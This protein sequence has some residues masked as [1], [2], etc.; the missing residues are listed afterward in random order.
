[1]RNREPLFL[2]SY[3]MAVSEEILRRSHFAD[4]TGVSYLFY[5]ILAVSCLM[6]LLKIALDLYDGR[7]R[8]SY[9]VFLIAGT[10][11]MAFLVL[12]GQSDAFM[13]LWLFIA[14]SHDVDFKKIIKTAAISMLLS[15]LLVFISGAVGIIENTTVT[16]M[17]EG[18]EHDRSGLG[19][20]AAYHPAYFFFFGMLSWFYY[21]GKKLSLFEIAVFAAASAYIFKQSDTRG[22][23]LLSVLLIVIAGIYRLF[24]AFAKHRRFY[25]VLGAAVP[26]MAAAFII[27]QG[28]EMYPQ[29]YTFTRI[30][31]KKLST[32]LWLNYNGVHTYGITLLGQNINWSIGDI[33]NVAY[34]WVDSVYL[35]SLLSYGVPFLLAFLYT[36]GR[37]SVS[38]GKKKDTFM[39][40][41]LLLIAVLGMLDN[42]C[43]RVE[44][45]P[46]YLGLS[47]C[48]TCAKGVNKTF[49]TS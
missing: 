43:F 37:L 3:A 24:P 6:S 28:I 41:A 21:R 16:R 32:R 18:E 13:V 25:T 40:I 7:I 17:R 49:T 34:N 19:F 42:Y 4:I 11:Y 20:T 1:M 27:Y 10:A 36:S 44:C 46:F 45:N 48:S 39:I 22:P 5:G 31:N 47:Y 15:V 2:T 8:R 26:V 33:E 9:L 14:A 12:R 29:D 35:Y 38:A 30:L 23:F